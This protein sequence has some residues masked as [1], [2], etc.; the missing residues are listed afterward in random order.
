MKKDEVKKRKSPNIKDLSN[1]INSYDNEL[2]D[3][4][5]E[6]LEIIQEEK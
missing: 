3:I 5:K 4:Q 2:S 1:L 6:Q